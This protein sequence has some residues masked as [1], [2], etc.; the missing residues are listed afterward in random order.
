[1]E[2]YLYDFS[3]FDGADLDE[4]ACYGYPYLDRYWSEPGRSPFLIRVDGILAGFVLVFEHT[5]LDTPGHMIAEFFILRKYRRLGVGR[6]A[7]FA[8]FDRFPGH[9]EISQISEN[10]PAQ[11]FWRKIIAEYTR[12]AFREIYL[13]DETWRGPVQTFENGSG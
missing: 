5:F 6:A 4:E 1:M 9:W 11:F 3:E 10:V 2:L 13:D 7:A 8:A 12:G